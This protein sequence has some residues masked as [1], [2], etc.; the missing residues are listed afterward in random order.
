MHYVN[1]WNA[2][3]T[4]EDL[5]A[6]IKEK[7]R[8]KNLFAKLNKH[9]FA[10]KCE[11]GTSNRREWGKLNDM[12]IGSGSIK[13]SIKSHSL[14]TLASCIEYLSR[15]NRVLYL[16]TLHL[17]HWHLHTCTLR[18]NKNNHV[19]YFS[20]LNDVI[21]LYNVMNEKFLFTTE[22]TFFFFNVDFFL[23]W[24]QLFTFCMNY[25]GFCC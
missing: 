15:K 12:L 4:K 19:V 8:K 17:R 6:M 13:K 11:T 23:L 25:M 5:D 3:T 7:K 9:V 22:N 14:L 21:T 24:N 16:C 1:A 10:R 2:Y 18:A 20:Y